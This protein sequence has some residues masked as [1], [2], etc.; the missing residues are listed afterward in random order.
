MTPDLGL[1]LPPLG[2]RMT[3]H[4][5]RMEALLRSYHKRGLTLAVCCDGK[6]LRRA[7]STLKRYARMFG[8]SF[9]DYRPRR[10]RRSSHKR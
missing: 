6:H 10:R 3:P 4:R 9:S 8:L 1:S 7:K 2:V 5:K